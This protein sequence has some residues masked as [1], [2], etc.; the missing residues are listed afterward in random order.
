[1]LCHDGSN[2]KDSTL[3]VHIVYESMQN[4]SLLVVIS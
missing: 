2:S 4:I 1:M 3:P